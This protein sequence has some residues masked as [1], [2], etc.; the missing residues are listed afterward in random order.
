MEKQKELAQS[1]YL[2]QSR[3]SLAKRIEEARKDYLAD[4]WH[5]RFQG[6]ARFGRMR[7][8]N[9]FTHD[10]TVQMLVEKLREAL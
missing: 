5:P 3:Q 1:E 10:K 4:P 9:D 7:V 6:L 2:A 8:M